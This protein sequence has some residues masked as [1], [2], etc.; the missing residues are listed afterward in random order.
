ME[1]SINSCAADSLRPGRSSQINYIQ[2]PSGGWVVLFHHQSSSINIFTDI[3]SV[4]NLLL[5]ILRCSPCRIQFNLI[6]RRRANSQKS[7]PRQ[8]PTLIFS[9]QSQPTTSPKNSNNIRK[10]THI[11]RVTRDTPPIHIHHTLTPHSIQSIHTDLTAVL[12]TKDLILT[13]T[14]TSNRRARGVVVREETVQACTID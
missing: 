3:T 5:Y 11:I 9:F 10:P 13:R 1:C 6:K 8:L 7:S 12:N 2:G 4:T 14:P